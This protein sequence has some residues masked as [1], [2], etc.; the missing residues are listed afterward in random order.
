M[1]E[2]PF[3]GPSLSAHLQSLSTPRPY[4]AAVEH[5]FLV[6]AGHRTLTP[7]ALSLYLCQDRIYAAHAYPHLIGRLL[8]SIPFSSAHTPDSEEE[9]F[10]RRVVKL[11]SY[12]LEN[13]VREV[14]FFEETARTYGLKTDWP[15]RKETRDYMAE[16][17]RVG[18]EGG[19]EEI[20]VFLWAMENVS[21]PSPVYGSSLIEAINRSTSMHG[22]SQVPC[23]PSWA[24]VQS[25]V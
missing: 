4:T 3:A 23:S 14:G 18:A 10:H 5:E 8:S 12:A 6:A 16:M 2:N 21:T 24:T 1:S 7:A 22:H 17:A 13:V 25:T 9:A 20:L 15:E 19:F 11:C